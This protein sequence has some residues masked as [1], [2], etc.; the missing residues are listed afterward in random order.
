MNTDPSD[1]QY[2]GRPSTTS[3]CIEGIGRLFHCGE[4]INLAWL[5]SSSNR[6]AFLLHNSEGELFVIKAGFTSG[7]LGEGPKGLSTALQMLRRH[8]VEIKELQVSFRVIEKLN[9]ALLTKKDLDKLA[10][11]VPV[12]PRRWDEYV[13]QHSPSM[14]HFDVVKEH[15]P[16]VIPFG[17]ID[18]RIF[19]LAL[20]FSD[21]ADAAVVGA[22]RRLEDGV[23]SRTG[24]SESGAKLFSKA[25]TA[26]GS[27]L[28]WDRP[29]DSESKGR[30]N[31]FSATYTAFRNAR[32][33][34][35][36]YQSREEELREFL[37]I[38][39]LFRLEAEAVV[40]N[41]AFHKVVKTTG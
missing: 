26:E 41:S 17:L 16:V 24:L 5:L 13:F 27:P 23:R 11:T 37:L 2:L 33:H 25:F 35:E 14:R 3:S 20:R 12:H 28:C 38:N 22:Y 4:Q 21:D 34:R 31:L 29:D 15:Y 19:D 7:Y 39:E 1:I 9:N 8:G 10:A 32:A 36:M 40:R 6:H 30:G 18:D